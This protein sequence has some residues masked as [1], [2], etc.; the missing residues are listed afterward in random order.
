MQLS[1]WQPGL[2]STFRN[3][4]V[5]ADWLVQ[6]SHNII[7]RRWPASTGL[8][9][10]PFPAVPTTRRRRRRSS[11]GRSCNAVLLLPLLLP[12]FCFAADA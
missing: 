12:V 6:A 2:S 1:N 3:V 10:Q 4:Q 7:D 5:R 8:C 9:A 11:T